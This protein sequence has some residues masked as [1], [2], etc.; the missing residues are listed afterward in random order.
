MTLDL[1]GMAM[2][3]LNL[4]YC[5]LYTD[6]KNVMMGSQAWSNKLDGPRE[7][8]GKAL[9]SPDVTLISIIILKA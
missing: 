5:L 9:H 8:C 3:N 4:R 2:T 1:K 6:L 7:Q